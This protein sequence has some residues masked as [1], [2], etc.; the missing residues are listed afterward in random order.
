MSL[1]N[2]YIIKKFFLQFIALLAGFTL[3]FLIGSLMMDADQPLQIIAGT[4]NM[5]QNMA[6]A[7]LQ[8]VILSHNPDLLYLMLVLS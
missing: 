8:E 1:L 4:E 7:G 5:V 3:L 2:L 6:Q